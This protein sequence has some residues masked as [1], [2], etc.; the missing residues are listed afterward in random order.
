MSALTKQ[1][2]RIS[3]HRLL[4]WILLAALVVVISVWAMITPYAMEK[5]YASIPLDPIRALVYSPKYLSANEDEEIRFAFENSSANPVTVTLGLENNSTRTG[6][7]GLQESNLVYS[8]TVFSRQ[9]VNRQTKVFFF[10]DP[11][12]LGNI[13]TQVSRLGLW[14]SI[15]NARFEQKDLD[16]HLAPISQARS[17]SYYLGGILSGLG[18]F[19]L[20]EMWNEAKRPVKKELFL[21]FKRIGSL[22]LGLWNQVKKPFRKSR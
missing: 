17:L 3:P 11:S 6:F 7:L 4:L 5:Y 14:A 18:I 22:F 21:E 20:R 9:Q 1:N 12:Q 10:V 16:I 2:T 19:F 8:G 13:D 15:D